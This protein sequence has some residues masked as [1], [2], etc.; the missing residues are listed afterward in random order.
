MRKVALFAFKGDPTCFIHVLLNALDLKKKNYEAQIIIEGEATKLVPD[1]TKKND[2]LAETFT[3]AK[4]QGLIAG[5]CRACSM[6]MKTLEDAE[7]QH[8]PLLSNM[9]GHPS[10][11]E[12]LD[13]GYGIITF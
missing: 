12:F 13:D 4:E 2:F 10:M 7:T 6:K 5:V 8:L 3:E 9:S 11:G 1:F